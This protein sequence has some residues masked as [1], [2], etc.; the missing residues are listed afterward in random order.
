MKKKTRDYKFV[1]LMDFFFAEYLRMYGEIASVDTRR[2]DWT[3]FGG[4][5]KF[6]DFVKFRG[7]FCRI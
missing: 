6:S 7:F 3:S 5:L 4:K 1:L 2:M